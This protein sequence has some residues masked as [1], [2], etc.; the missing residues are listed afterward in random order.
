[1]NTKD[2]HENDKSVCADVGCKLLDAIVEMSS[3]HMTRSYESRVETGAISA[4]CS[5]LVVPQR[6]SFDAPFACVKDSFWACQGCSIV[7]VGVHSP[8]L[9]FAFLS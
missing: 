4:F 7:C 5:A 3:M 9:R 1:M 2:G 6:Q 8:R